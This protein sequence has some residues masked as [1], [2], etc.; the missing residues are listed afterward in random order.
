[1]STT[2]GVRCADLRSLS[3]KPWSKGNRSD[4]VGMERKTGFEPVTFSLARRWG[5]C[6]CFESTLSERRTVAVW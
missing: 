1:R 5:R 3:Q 2:Q 6:A 4:Q